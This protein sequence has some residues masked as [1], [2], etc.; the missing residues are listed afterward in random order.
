MSSVS[1]D[2]GEAYAP[3]EA[4]GGYRTA[5]PGEMIAPM[6]H[7]L[8][9]TARRLGPDTVLHLDGDLSAGYLDVDAAYWHHAGDH[10]E[11]AVGRVVSIF[12]YTSTWTWWERHPIGDEVAHVL[13]GQAELLLEDHLGRR[14]TVPLAPATSAIIPAGAWHRLD[15][16]QQTSVLFV[17]PTPARTEHRPA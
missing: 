9:P 2:I 4:T 1:I 6:N 10:P 14:A 3:R 5:G 17:T 8:V 12:E 16:T 15:V 13:S 7:T 11:L